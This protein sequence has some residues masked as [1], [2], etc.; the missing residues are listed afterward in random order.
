M[1]HDQSRAKIQR[2]LRLAPGTIVGTEFSDGLF[3]VFVTADPP[4]ANIRTSESDNAL[5][6]RK[7]RETSHE[8]DRRTEKRMKILFFVAAGVLLAWTL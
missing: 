3:A 6:W 4:R 1:R 8:A 2:A 7:W 5:R